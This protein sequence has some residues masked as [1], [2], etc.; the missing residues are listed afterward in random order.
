[1]L[2]SFIVLFI[3]LLFYFHSENK[4]ESR[5]SKDEKIW[6]TRSKNFFSLQLLF[7]VVSKKVLCY[8]STLFGKK[9]NFISIYKAEKNEQ[10]RGKKYMNFSSCFSIIFLLLFLKQIHYGKF[11]FCVF[12]WRAKQQQQ[13]WYQG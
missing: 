8:C 7:V 4:S 2:F 9:R 5:R 6:K 11:V 10:N 3:L 12:V 1:M 13:W